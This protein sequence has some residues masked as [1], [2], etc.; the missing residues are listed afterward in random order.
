M[1][2]FVLS[3][4]ASRRTPQPAQQRVPLRHQIRARL[5]PRFT[6]VL[7]LLRSQVPRQWR[8]QVRWITQTD[9]LHVESP[10]H[11]IIRRHLQLELARACCELVLTDCSVSIGAVSCRCHVQLSPA[12]GH[13]GV[14]ST[15]T[16]YTG[17]CL[18]ASPAAINHSV[19]L[20]TPEFRSTRR[21]H[22]HPDALLPHGERGA[23]ATPTQT[24]RIAAPPSPPE[25][26]SL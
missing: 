4:G 8:Q 19:A 3:L 2:V 7:L 20:T 11:Q 15:S 17:C 1:P 5:R 21:P 26:P 23:S 9:G 13:A 25:D 18:T 6:N 22:V 14:E 10:V 24:K 12:G 16:M